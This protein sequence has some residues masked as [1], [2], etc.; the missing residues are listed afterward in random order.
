MVD[1]QLLPNNVLCCEKLTD[2]I[3][4]GARSVK[5]PRD[6]VVENDRDTGEK[7]VYDR[8]AGEACRRP[9][10]DIV[11]RTDCA[12]IGGAGKERDCCRLDNVS[13]V[14]K[15]GTVMSR[16]VDSAADATCCL[17]RTSR[18]FCAASRMR[19]VAGLGAW[20]NVDS[21]GTIPPIG[22]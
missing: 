19:T 9:G 13:E 20:M 1:P 12:V 10:R 4:A 15:C 8:M 14:M 21:D 22:I 18:A 5:G 16:A 2:D 11:L 7:I 17:D 6:A 3:L